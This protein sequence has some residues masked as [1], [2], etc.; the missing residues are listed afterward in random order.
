MKL[1]KQFPKLCK[2]GDDAVFRICFDE[3]PRYLFCDSDDLSK[4]VDVIEISK[5]DK[6][7]WWKF[8][9]YGIS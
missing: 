3:N 6:M 1:W 8:A 2:D 4:Q 9:D 7:H 5:W